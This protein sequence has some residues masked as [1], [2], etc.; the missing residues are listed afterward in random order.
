MASEQISAL[1]Y[2]AIKKESTKGTPVTPNVYLPFFSE[3]VKV[4][5]G[6]EPIAPIMGL[7]T[8]R[9]SAVR[10]QRSFTGEIEFL[11][12]PNV[13]GYILDMLLTKGTTTGA[14]PYTHPFT[15]STSAN[16]NSYSFDVKKGRQTWRLWGV[17]A[18]EAA[19][20]FDKNQM[21]IKLKVSALGCLSSRKITNNASGVLTLDTT[22]HNVPVKGFVASD[23]VRIFKADGTVIDTSISSLDASANTITVASFSG[24]ASGDKVTLRESAPSYTFTGDYFTFGRTEFRFADTA[25]NALSA[26]HT[27]LEEDVVIKIMHKF[28]PEEGIRRSGSNDPN[29]LVRGTGDVEFECKIFFD[30]PDNQQTFLDTSQQAMVIRAFAGAS[31]VHELRIT[32]NAMIMNESPVNIAVNEVLMSD[33]KWMPLYKTADTQMFDVKSINAIATI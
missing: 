22:Y 30:T 8:E 16:P 19:I 1:S 31:N 4:D 33:I 17:E 27:P 20:V 15:L 25:A 18:S 28:L 3:N 12:E 2:L 6:I 14:N 29:S 26:T 24:V 21:K 5:M 13:L 11:G 7:K 10:G 9:F 23:L 32:L